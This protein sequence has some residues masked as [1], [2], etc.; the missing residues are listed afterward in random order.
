LRGRIEISDFRSALPAALSAW[1]GYPLRRNGFN[2]WLLG[3][4]IGMALV[5]SRVSYR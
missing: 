5:E 4:V 1:L 2:A 3:V